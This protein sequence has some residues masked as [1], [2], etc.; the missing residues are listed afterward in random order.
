MNQLKSFTI[1]TV[2]TL[3]LALLTALPIAKA[4]D[5]VGMLDRDIP[6]S[7]LKTSS[8][9]IFG[10]RISSHETQNSHTA[11]KRALN[12]DSAELDNLNKTLRLLKAAEK[13]N[14]F[15]KGTR[16]S[17]TLLTR[18]VARHVDATRPKIVDPEEDA[19]LAAK[20]AKKDARA[21][22]KLLSQRR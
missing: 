18:N 6:T 4:E 15:R 3:A 1:S 21:K 13:S 19:K 20:Q 22:K 8:H 11:I 16:K 2:L 10:S 12:T 17:D 7:Q 5:D 9:S 14:A